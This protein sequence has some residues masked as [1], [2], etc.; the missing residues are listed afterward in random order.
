MYARF[1]CYFQWSIH[2]TWIYLC[3]DVKF[4]FFTELKIRSEN[5]K[6]RN[7]K[8]IWEYSRQHFDKQNL[9][10]PAECDDFWNKFEHMW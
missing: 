4:A 10:T 7:I 5:S 3:Q 2:I 8:M 1:D 6:F 9:L